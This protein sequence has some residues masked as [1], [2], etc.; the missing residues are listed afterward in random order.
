MPK[1]GG[2]VKRVKSACI[3]Q[4]L[5][6]TQKPELGYSRELALKT[7][8]EEVEHYKATLE[9][10]RTKYQRVNVAE[11]E[12][13]SYTLLTSVFPTKA[14]LVRSSET[15]CGVKY[16]PPDFPALEAYIPIRNS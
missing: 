13:G 1:G 7:N 9:R 8:R 4:T 11:Q 15:S 12:A 14:N 5:L 2:T 6:F 10:A 16:S 3:L